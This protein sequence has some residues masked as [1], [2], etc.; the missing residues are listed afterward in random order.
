LMLM[1]VASPLVLDFDDEISVANDALSSFSIPLE[2]VVL[3]VV[4]SVTV[5]AAF[6]SQVE[7]PGRPGPT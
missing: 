7:P 1:V 3:N 5:W 4:L 2:T 6:H